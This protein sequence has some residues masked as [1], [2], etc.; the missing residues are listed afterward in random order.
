MIRQ[1][2]LMRF[3]VNMVKSGSTLAK[4]GF[5]TLRDLDSNG[6]FIIKCSKGG[7]HAVFIHSIDRN[8]IIS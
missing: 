8:L 1:S 4:G 3:G 2:L 6:D 7:W 5:D